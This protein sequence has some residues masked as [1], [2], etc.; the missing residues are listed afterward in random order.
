MGDDAEVPMNDNETEGRRAARNADV[1]EAR[2]L[3]PKLCSNILL[4]MDYN[5]W[6]SKEKV[7]AHY[8]SEL[9]PQAI[10]NVPWRSFQ[11]SQHF[12]VVNASRIQS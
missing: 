7:A 3:M 11:F 8:I 4:T 5:E 9:N 10:P 6:I 12:N 1:G 2:S